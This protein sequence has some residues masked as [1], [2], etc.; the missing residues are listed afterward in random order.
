MATLASRPNTELTS[1]H[2]SFAHLDQ[3]IDPPPMVEVQIRSFDNLK[4][5][6]IRELLNEV[7][8]IHDATGNRYELHFVEHAFRDPKHSE[9]ECSVKEITF[10]A[11]L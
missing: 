11:P 8:P 9:E 1:N 5:D 6:G 3:V 10:E 2:K 4:T 7:N